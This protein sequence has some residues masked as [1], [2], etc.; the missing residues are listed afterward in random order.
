MIRNYLKI[1]LRNLFRNSI[2]SFINIGGLAVGIACSL[3]ILLWVWDEVSYDRF[4]KN[5]DQLGQL[6]LHDHFTDNI[7][8]SPAVVLATYEHLKTFDNRIKNTSV[9]YWPNKQMISVGENKV[10]KVGQF[11]SPEFLDMFQF[12]LV[13]GSASA[14]KDPTSILIN[15]ST[16]KALFPN[17][18]AM[19]QLVKLDNKND[20]KVAGIL[21]DLP[22]NSTFDFEFL[23]PWIIYG[24]GWAKRDK[25][26][27]GN[28]SYPVYV[29]LQPGTNR[30]EVNAKLTTLIQEKRKDKTE[31]FIHPLTDWR[32]RSN[33]KEGKQDGGMIDYV[34][35]F[36]FIALFILVIA[37]INFMNLATAR[38]ERRAREVGIRKS[39]GSRRRELIFQFIGESIMIAALAFVAAVII[40]E[41]VLP[42]YNN[43]VEKRLFIDYS[44]PLV[45]AISLGF[46]LITGFFAGSYPAFY[47]SSFQAAKV[48]KGNVHA[49]RGAV[50]PRKVLVS[51]Q[52]FFSISL[53]VGMA[54]VYMQIQ[55]VKQRDIG[56]DRENLVMIAANEE[57]GKNFSAI[58]KEL[59][60]TGIAKSVTVSSSPVTE[61]YGN[62]ILGWPGKPD[63]QQILFSRVVTG[64][65]YTK[66]MGIK[67]TE[68]RDFSED[69]KSD[70]SAMLLNQAAVDAIGNK[71]PIGMQIDL[72]GKKW[73]VIGVVSNVL[74]AS[75]FRE[76]Q[77]GFFLLEPSWGETVTVRLD[78]TH[79]LKENLSKMESVF[80]KFNP[81]Y[82]FEY[83]FVDAQFGKKFSSINLIGTL[84][85]LFA[86]LA[87][88]ITCLG[89]FGLATFTA[90]QRTKE[91]GIRKVMGASTSSI[92]R[93]LSKDFTI[94]VI[95]G[96]S[97]SAPVSWYAMDNYL[98]RYNYRIEFAWWI[99]PVAGAIALALTLIIV[100]SQAIRAASANP[101]QSLRS[102]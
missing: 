1:A 35:S 4:H 69:F 56:Y 77:P 26:D 50:A 79:E 39:I 31:M 62:N 76:V 55:H 63:D 46:I 42:L 2:Y 36:T 3:L 78:K 58:E 22:H 13:K 38:S 72:W 89:L 98:S 61:I 41:L 88:F 14:L 71:N 66:T 19:G 28:E 100:S 91:I 94:L 81:S 65:N 68:G 34:K 29:E 23:A 27:W 44:S 48:L 43:L 32:L 18:D 47:L 57:M 83:Q 12:P 15:E 37:C 60:S 97:L 10:T 96:L 92:I 67:I 86:F 30:D 102:E 40:V 75:P 85:S 20:F 8:T 49:S 59:I 16:A 53:I 93:L 51:L 54:V 80:K 17:Q 52:F 74:M 87:I 25:D 70:S 11:V 82:P 5:A 90:E 101:A 24:E 9:A 21:K 7:A 99:I 73:N 6:M 95:I 33:F 64:Y 45:W 84:A